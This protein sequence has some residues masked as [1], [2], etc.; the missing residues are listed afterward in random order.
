M[1]QKITDENLE[2]VR[3]ETCDQ[4]MEFDNVADLMS[5]LDSGVCKN[6]AIALEDSDRAA[7]ER[8]HGPGS[9]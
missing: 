1:N 2:L 3:C 8:D 6:C 5:A 9:V 7:F 4:V